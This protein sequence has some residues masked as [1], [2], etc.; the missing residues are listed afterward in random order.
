MSYALGIDIG[1]TNTKFGVVDEAGV[2]LYQDSIVTSVYSTPHEFIDAISHSYQSHIDAEMQKKISRIGIGAPNGNYYTGNIEH[3]ANL[4]WKGIIP[5]AKWIENKFSKPTIITN[6]ANASAMGEMIYGVAKGMKDFI[7]VTLGTG[8]GSGFV[9]NGKLILGHDGFAGELG[10]VI[11]IRNGRL[12]GCGR[13][14]CLETYTSA[15]GIVITAN[16]ILMQSKEASLLREAHTI[17][18]KSIHDA[19][20]LGDRIALQIFDYTANILGQTLADAVAITSPEAIILFGGLSLAGDFI[21]KPT[22][23]YM[24]DNLLINYKGK[25]KILSSAFQGSDAAILGAAALQ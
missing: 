11:A 2:I 14:G 25:V 4:K 21:L 20:L 1:G 5:M 7:M 16:E 13:K 23:Q 18:S 8:V 12:C 17:T 6:D 15:T 9:A 3:A 10:H 22:Q 24:D 19:A